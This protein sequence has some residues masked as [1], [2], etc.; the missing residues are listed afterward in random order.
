MKRRRPSSGQT[1]NW[2]I[3]GCWFILVVTL[4]NKIKCLSLALLF[5]GNPTNNWNWNCIYMGTTNSKPPGPIIMID[6]SK[7][8]SRRQVQFITLF[9]GGAQLH[10][11][12]AMA[13]CCEC[14]AE[15]PI[16]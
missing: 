2:C 10:L 14:G 7:V 15:K 9:F 12:P 3:G 8:L 4:D 13:S 6:Q 5:F 1:A 16:C 11:L